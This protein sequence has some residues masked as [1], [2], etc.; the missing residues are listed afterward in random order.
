MLADCHVHSEFSSDS[1]TPVTDMLNRAVACGMKYFYLTDHHD[2]DFPVD[3]ENGMD[4]QLDTP[5]YLTRIAE[6]TDQYREQ[7]TVRTGVELGLMAHIAD[8]WRLMSLIITLIL[9]LVLL[10]WYA[11]WILIIPLTMK[12]VPRPR[13]TGNILNLF[14]KTQKPFRIMM[15]TVIW[16]MWSAMV[17]HRIKAGISGIMP[18]FSK[19]SLKI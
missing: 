10:I 18:M 12:A 14:T 6:L 13:L 9:S 19:R 15:Y 4:F 16:I 1:E 11:V 8:N 3:A 7:I 2:I 17:Q 5:S